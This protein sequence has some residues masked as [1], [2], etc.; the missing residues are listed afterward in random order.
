MDIV[1][2]KR[3]DY[4]NIQK[5]KHFMV[6]RFAAGFSC[7]TGQTGSVLAILGIMRSWR[8]LQDTTSWPQDLR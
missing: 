8:G 5:E 1:R 2:T 6:S 4:Q 3:A 7:G